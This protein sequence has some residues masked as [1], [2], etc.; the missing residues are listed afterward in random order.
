MS[1]QAELIEDGKRY[2]AKNYKQLPVVFVRGAGTYL[3]D[4]EDKRYLD[5]IG[6]IAVCALGHCPPALVEVLARQAATLMHVSNLY[7]NEPQIQLA[8][9]LCEMSFADRVFFCNSGAE[10]NEAAVKLARRYQ[11]E[12]RGEDR[13]EII[14]AEGSFHGRTLAMIAATGQEKYRQGFGPMPAGFRH[15]PFGNLDAMRDAIGD[16]TAAIMVEPIQGEGGMVMP[17][18]GY[19]VGLRN[20]CD[21]TNVLLIFDE[22]QSGLGRTGKLFAHEHEGITPDIMSLAKALGGGFPIGAMLSS[23]EVAGGFAPGMHASTFGGNALAAAVGLAATT[24]IA[25]PEFLERVNVAGQR[26]RTALEILRSRFPFVGEVRGRGLWLGVDVSIDGAKIVDR[27]FHRGLLL[28]HIGGRVLRFAPPLNI[29]DD[30]I[31][32]AV[33]ILGEVCG[34]HS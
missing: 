33:R 4:A 9:F 29:S 18:P 6:G 1:R 20:L 23:E 28:N 14:C 32:E 27:A 3:W 2:L 22:I 7:F 30:E 12:V 10:A 25:A 15:V 31:D 11:R 5:C 19:L 26:L 8:K 17:P 34:E 21:E 16:H 13:Y 24:T